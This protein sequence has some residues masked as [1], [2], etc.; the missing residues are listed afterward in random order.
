MI[1]EGYTDS[2]MCHQFGVGNV[3]SVL[4]TS[5]TS[6]HV[7]LLRRFADR[8][9][10]LFDPDLA[11]DKAVDRAVEL[12]LTQPIEVLV[13]TLPEQLDPDE[14]LLEHGAEGFNKVI[15]EAQD[16]LNY[17]WKQLDKRYR[18]S[19]GDMTGQ[20]KAVEEYLTVWPMLGAAA[21][22]IRCAGAQ[23]WPV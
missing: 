2:I 12:F 19:E 6:Q 7:T 16:A 15:A 17:K 18:T 22:W 9:V 13:A 5:L 14:Y 1:V 8:I 21:R 23:A 11:G 20:Q 4:G 10:L 3:V